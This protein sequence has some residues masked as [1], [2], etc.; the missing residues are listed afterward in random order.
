MLFSDNNSV[1]DKTGLQV[2]S[3]TFIL[4]LGIMSAVTGMLK[5][6]S[7]VNNGLFILGDFIPAAAGIVAG[8]ILIFGI[9]RQ[10]TASKPGELDRIGTNLL[11]FRKPIS[12]GLMVSAVLHF[13]FGE[14]IFL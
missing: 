8:L 13:I 3:P 2:N 4:V 1:I 12:F 7:P 6:L 11:V 5:L 10:N 9:Y 14:I